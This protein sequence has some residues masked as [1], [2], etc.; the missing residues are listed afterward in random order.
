MYAFESDMKQL[1]ARVERIEELLNLTAEDP[2]FEAELSKMICEKRG[3]KYKNIE[4]DL[5]G[6]KWGKERC[7]RCSH[8][9]S[10]SV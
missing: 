4:Y 9:Y 6:G 8:E 3:H 7:E 10:W 2:E 1:I 5:Q